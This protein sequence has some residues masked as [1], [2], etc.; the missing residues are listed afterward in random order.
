[1][2]TSYSANQ[3]AKKNEEG[4]KI[5]R[6]HSANKEKQFQKGVRGKEAIRWAKQKNKIKQIQNDFKDRKK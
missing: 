4:G 1:M 6:R 3:F 2:E 5:R